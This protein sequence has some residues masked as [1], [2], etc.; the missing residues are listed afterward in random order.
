MI[1]PV[2][3][4]LLFASPA[5][6][7]DWNQ[8]P[9]PRFDFTTDEAAAVPSA[10]SVTLGHNIAWKV[11]LPETG[12]ST[13]VISGDR[14]FL[15]TMKPVEI[16]TKYSPD[17]VA[18]C[19]SVKDGALL[20]QRDIPGGYQTKLSGPYG[21]ASA[22]APVTDGRRVW[23][24]NPSGRLCCF[25]LEGNPV[26]SKGVTSTV[27]T[28]PVLFEGKL[29][30]HHQ[31]YL[32]NATGAF[33]FEHANAPLGEWT[34]LQALD[35]A[36]GERVW[37]TQCGVNMACVPLVQRLADGTAVL[38]VGRGGGHAPPEKPIG[39]SLIRADT[40]EAIWSLPGPM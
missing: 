7:A 22:P 27:Y 33:L 6:A 29:L 10:W 14:I 11:T 18:W 9:G 23:V 12:Q 35:A 24:L 40:G 31:V 8:G 37:L 2:F 25:D 19:F 34:Q 13:P 4:S 3:L 26:W 38:M 21:D 36:T 16:D 1:R 20:W 15:T 30:L 5:A 17:I 39:I 32:P 28:Q